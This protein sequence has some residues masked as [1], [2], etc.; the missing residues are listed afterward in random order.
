MKKQ[1]G[2][3]LIELVMV[4]VIIGILAA[5][6]IPKFV[7]LRSDAW[8]GTV[9]GIAGAVSSAAVVNNASCNAKAHVVTANKCV[10]VSK[11]SEAVALINGAPTL[12][13]AGAAVVGSYN[14]AADTTSTTNDALTTCTLQYGVATGSTASATFTMLSAGN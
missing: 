14:L 7:D 9:N 13:T 10:K 2:F 3:T 12:A 8:Q 1:M 11:C 6:A 4:M 5:V